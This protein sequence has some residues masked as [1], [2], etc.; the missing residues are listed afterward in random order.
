MSAAEFD[1]LVRAFQKNP[2]LLAEFRTLHGNPDRQLQWAQEKGF[3]LTR[4]ELERLSDSDQALS[5][6]DLE[7]VAGG[8]DGWTPGP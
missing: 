4:E 7:Q 1:L 3:Q 5:D 6:D 2:D 8:D